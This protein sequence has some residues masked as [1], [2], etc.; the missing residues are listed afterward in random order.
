MAFGPGLAGWARREGQ[1]A[2]GL[3]IDI[4]DENGDPVATV[5]TAAD[6]R[7]RTLA[8]PGTYYLATDNGAGF[9]DQVFSQVPCPNGPASQGL[10][11]PLKG[12][13]VVVAGNMPATDGI[14]FDLAAA[15]SIFRDGFES[16]DFSSWSLASAN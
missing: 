11:D 5:V 14:F 16:G 15:S 4:F 8:A 1:A 9:V 7:F 6:G 13:P 10:C 3:E 2:A 12:D